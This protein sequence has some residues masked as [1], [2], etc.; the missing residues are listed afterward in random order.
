MENGSAVIKPLVT[1]T[2]DG[3]E[4]D[5]FV[6]RL[7]EGVPVAEE[8]VSGTEESAS[9]TQEGAC[10]TEESALLCSRTSWC[11]APGVEESALVWRSALVWSALVSR[12]APWCGGER[13]GV[14]ESAHPGVEESTLVW[15]KAPWCG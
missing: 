1:R 13:P 10:G 5:T 14:K 12:R 3:V 2:S 7:E 8:G 11:R 9:G 4:D 6:K 15:R